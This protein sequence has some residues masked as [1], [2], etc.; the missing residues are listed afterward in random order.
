MINDADAVL[1]TDLADATAMFVAC[2]SGTMAG[3]SARRLSS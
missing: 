3:C 2:A 1:V